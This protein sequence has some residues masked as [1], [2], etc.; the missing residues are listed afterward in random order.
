[1]GAELHPTSVFLQ[2]DCSNA[3][4]NVDRAAAW[5]IIQATNPAL[6]AMWRPWVAAPLAGLLATGDGETE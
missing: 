1:M 2:L 5:D 3:F 6:A 4:G